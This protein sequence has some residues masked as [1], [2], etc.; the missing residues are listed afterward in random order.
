MKGSSLMNTTTRELQ[1]LLQQQQEQNIHHITLEEEFRFY[2]RIAQGD[3]TILEKNIDAEPIEGMGMLSKDSLRNMKYHQ[4]IFIAMVTRF[5]IEEGLPAEEAYTLSDLYIRRIDQTTSKKDLTLIKK[6]SITYYTQ[7]MSTLQ[8]RKLTS[9]PVVLASDYIECHLTEPLTAKEIGTAVSSNEDY[10]SR[11]FKKETGLT[12]KQYVLS[13]KCSVAKYMLEN[14]N[15]SCTEI[16]TFLG[17]A[18]CSYF[19]KC[20]KQIEKK[21]PGQ[22]RSSRVRNI[23]SDF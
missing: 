23:I 7:M 19:I 11:L 22:Y 12:L 3:L 10:L 8:T 6:E 13:R 14:S 17:F 21:T 5:C 16:S 15:I 9:L 20:F 4:I 1:K 2:R 18:S